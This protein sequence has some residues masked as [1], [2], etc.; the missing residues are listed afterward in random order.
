MRFGPHLGVEDW[1]VQRE[2]E[3]ITLIYS[4]LFV[5]A[6]GVQSLPGAFSDQLFIL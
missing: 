4:L 6:A 5:S 1:I 3:F 2:T